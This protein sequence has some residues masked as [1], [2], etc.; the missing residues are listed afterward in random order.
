MTAADLGAGWCGEALGKKQVAIDV[1]RRLARPGHDRAPTRTSS[2]PGPRC[3]PARPAARS[4]ISYTVSYS[5]G[6]DSANKDQAFVLL[7]Y[8]AGKDGMTKWTEGGVAL[9]SRKD[10]PTPAGKDVLAAGSAYARPGSGFMPGYDDVQKAFQD[11]FTDQIQKQDLRRRPGRRGHQGGHRQGPEPSSRR[12]A[13]VAAI[14]RLDR[15]RRRQPRR[16]RRPT[17]APQRHAAARA[18]SEALAGYAFIA[19]PMVLFLVLKIG[20]LLLRRSTSASGTGTSGPAR[21]SSS[22][23]TNYAERARPTRSS[24]GPIQNS[25]YYAVV[26]V[27]LTMAIGLFLAVIVNQKIR[28]QTFFRAAFYFPAIASSAAI[29]I[30]WIFI[31]SPDGLFNSVR[32]ALGSTRSSRSSGYGPNQNWIGDQDTA[33]NSVII[34]N[35]WTTSGTFMLFYLASLQ[36]ISDDGLRGGRD[37]RRRAPGRRSGRSPSRCS[38]RAT[39]S[40]RR[41]RSSGRSSCSTRRS[42]PAARTAIRTTR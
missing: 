14:D 39:T 37:R 38:A 22:G 3:R 18:R 11:A 10:V 6:A 42:S 8:L 40:W 30:L 5:I 25:L 35:A 27:P 19:V 2:T 33:L 26:W 12:P 4:T 32:A 16:R 9:P 15:G 7:T 13:T 1:R 28:G 23:S 17:S 20:A 41:W 34:L 36:A 29:T 31:V 24:S 21:S